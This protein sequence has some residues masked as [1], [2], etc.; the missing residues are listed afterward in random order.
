MCGTQH[1]IFP[2]CVGRAGWKIED[3]EIKT[4]AEKVRPVQNKAAYSNLC[5][6]KLS[7]PLKS[8]Q[9]KT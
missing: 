8:L 7:F 3:S 1:H 5:N 2:V 6:L 4:A 9:L